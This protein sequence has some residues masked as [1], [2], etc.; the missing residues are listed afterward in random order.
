MPPVDHRHY[1]PY[2]P[3]RCGVLVRGGSAWIGIHWSS[4]NRRFCINLIPFVT[5]WIVLKGGNTP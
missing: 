2:E 3:I 5:I 1:E 4:H